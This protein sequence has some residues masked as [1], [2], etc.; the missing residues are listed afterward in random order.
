MARREQ[1]PRRSDWLTDGAQLQPD[2]SS[3]RVSLDEPREA[4]TYQRAEHHDH[5]DQD[6]FS[7]G[8]SAPKSMK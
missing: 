2:A 6:E 8:A 7:N 5:G 3:V 4:V 1:L